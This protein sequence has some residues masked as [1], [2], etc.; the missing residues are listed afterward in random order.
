MRRRWG[1]CSIPEKAGARTGVLIT[2]KSR[3]QRGDRGTMAAVAGIWSKLTTSLTIRNRGGRQ[4]LKTA[5]NR[6]SPG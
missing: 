2:D 3:G 1:R 5:R 6:R 4:R